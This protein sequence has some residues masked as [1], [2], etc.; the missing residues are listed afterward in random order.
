MPQAH[1]HADF[2]H[3]NVVSS[4]SARYGTTPPGRL[5]ERAAELDMGLIALTDR[6]GVYGMVKH[7]RACQKAGLRPV[8]GCN[9]AVAAPDG[10]RVTLLARG[11]RGWASLC[12]LVTQ[13]HDTAAD[14][15]ALSLHALAQHADGLVVL[16]GPDSDVGTALAEGRPGLAQRLLDR[17]RATAET[18][19]ELVDHYTP[20]H[21][22]IAQALLDLAARTRTLAVLTNAVR[23][24]RATDAEVAHV[25]DEARRWLPGGTRPGPAT[26][27]AHLK[28]GA[29]MLEVA[30]RLCGDDTAARRL[31]AHT[32]ALA[33]SC[34][35]DPDAD[36]GMDRAHLPDVHD[37]R[38]R[39]WRD[40]DDG[41][42]R[43]GLHR[44]P[45]AV[46]RLAGELEVIERKGLSAYF[47]TVADAAARI[48]DKGIRCS[49]RGSGAGSLVNHLL[50]ISAINP[51]DHGLLMERFL[52]QSRV[53]LPDIDLDVES[54]RRLEAYDA[55]FAAY[56]DTACVSM[57][58]TYRARSAI[59][60]VGAAMGI[61][62]HEIDALAKAFPHVRA[63]R[64]RS[65]AQD[66]PELRG[67]QGTGL[68]SASAQTLF[69]LA[70]SLDGLPRHIA[71]HP[72][73]LV[74]SGSTLRERTPLEPS[75]AGYPM[76]QFDKEDVEEMGLIK[77]DVIGVR[78]Q[79]AMA[80][81]RDEVARTTGEQLDL[82]TLPQDESTYRMI[83]S[84][85]TL[86]C[87]QIESPGQRELVSRLRPADMDDLICD[88]SLFRPGPVGSDMITPYLAAREGL[89]PP[90][91]PSP[92]L[93]DLLAPTGGVVIFH[94]QVIGTL[95]AMTGCGLD[96]AESMRRR[97]G[98]EEGRAQVQRTFTTMA[99][100]CG[101][102]PRIIE[103]VWEILSSFGAFGFC[104]AHAAAFALPTYQSAWLKRHHPAAFYAG[105]LTH[106]PGMYPRRAIIDDARRFGVPVLGV[107][108][109][110]S[111][112]RWRVE[113]VG[114]TWGVRA[115]LAD[116]RGI[117]AAEIG[118]VLAERPFHSLPDAANRAR[119]SRDV[120]EN[121]VRV[122]AFDA[123][124]RIG[125]DPAAPHRRDLLLQVSALERAGRTRTD[126]GQIPLPV[127]GAVPERGALPEMSDDERVRAELE[128]L[129]YEVDRHLL[130]GHAELLAALA[131][132]HRLVPARDLHLVPNGQE[133]LVAGV[134]VATQT[135]AVRSGQRI[136]FT[137][138]DDAT[139]LVDLTFF[140][141]VQDRC[142]STVFGSWLLAVRGR[143]RRSGSG[144]ATVTATHAYDLG[145][146][147]TAWEESGAEGLADAL[148]PQGSARAPRGRGVG[149]PRIR[150]SSGFRVSPYADLP[151]VTA[152]PRGLWYA[153]PGSSGP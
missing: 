127:S 122:G 18:V 73:G 65:A 14:T 46:H 44:D 72:C 133:V 21:R 22:G 32:N 115:S 4:A 108:I 9:L 112:D 45:G 87:F 149:G 63:R 3:L 8:L 143:V 84:S 54:A 29:Q 89:S 53:G 101:H 35:M 150:Y 146:L 15:P 13:A 31:I 85:A 86:G 97:L 120:L 52:S 41:L 40:C 88:I 94:E 121:L 138:L 129:G 51:L 111:E 102:D 142:A 58:E 36:L 1:G 78:M 123:L 132:G 114:G 11:R 39:L 27:Q 91:H 47:L 23:Y 118:R 26:A 131:A 30:R 109:D 95:H 43:L 135:P 2:A 116:V 152:A 100:E 56:P 67:F 20:G 80:H 141:S 68:D 148:R 33:A 59:R 126:S 119:L 92:V 42:H 90:I 147:T 134:K 19:I 153:S 70:E 104:K 130:D 76:V 144:M 107:D 38:E 110:R 74:V 82:D 57:M 28:S 34:A 113:D 66:L 16:L 106:D 124:Y 12:R 75:R 81:T 69:R 128:V 50:G 48:R 103:R 137:T 98:T 62:P 61:P 77:L 96:Q 49:I 60:D 83:S 17:W 64:I 99:E 139:G 71:M 55:V 125:S 10:G 6:D 93:S 145:E 140:E 79:S 151:S 5:V 117:T 24:P 7:V 25:L 105:V 37:P 136:I